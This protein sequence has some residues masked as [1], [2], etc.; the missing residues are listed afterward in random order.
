MNNNTFVIIIVILILAILGVA[1]FA[2]YTISKGSKS[3]TSTNGSTS[4]SSNGSTRTGT[5]N[6]NSGGTTT[7]AS[8]TELETL[9]D[10]FQTDMTD[11]FTACEVVKELNAMP[12]NDLRTWASIYKGKYNRS[13]YEVMNDMWIICPWSSDDEEVMTKLKGL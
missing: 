12:T 7:V 9:A 11:S 10:K 5:T 6:S 2:I 1:G 4:N 3:T 8:N 13:A